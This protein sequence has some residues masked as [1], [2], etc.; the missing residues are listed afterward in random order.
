MTS[1]LGRSGE[2]GQVSGASRE[3]SEPRNRFAFASL[4]CGIGPWAT[5]ALYFL[6]LPW[7]NLPPAMLSSLLRV[8][9]VG[10]FAFPI[11]TV[12]A[13]VSGRVEPRDRGPAPPNPMPALSR[14]GND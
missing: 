13:I 10:F 5:L 12:L 3:R 6:L 4:F 14:N 9:G 8:N 11:L 2:A 7:L 1:M